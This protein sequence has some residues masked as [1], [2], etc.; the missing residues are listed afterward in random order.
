MR[1]REFERGK[2]ASPPD[3]GFGDK[4]PVQFYAPNPSAAVVQIFRAEASPA[5]AE[6]IAFSLAEGFCNQL[7][8]KSDRHPKWVGAALSSYV[9]FNKKQ[10]VSWQYAIAT[11]IA[12]K[13]S[14][15]LY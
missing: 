2:L 8:Y 10:Q 9:I 4:P 7:T 5:L 1:C 14:V 11:D 13:T 3:P 15:N 12:Q 6:S